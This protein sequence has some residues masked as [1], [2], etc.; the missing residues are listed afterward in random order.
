[1]HGLRTSMVMKRID[2]FLLLVLLM[3]SMAAQAQQSP[4]AKARV[5]QIRKAYTE[6]KNNVAAADKAAK[7][8]KPTNM[9]VV[10][11]IYTLGLGAGSVT[12]TYYFTE[13]EDTLLGRS[14]YKP[15]FIVN[16]YNTPGNKYY[17]EFLYD[18]DDDLIFYYEKNGGQ[19]TRLYFGKEGEND[20][21]GLVYEINTSSRTM[22]PPFA[23]RVGGELMHAFHLLMNREF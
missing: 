23:H 13:E 16:N 7:A 11:S 4:E 15:Y 5:A 14:F 2:I 8:G 10:N 12:T 20:D 22:E 6:A 3:G 9:T 19:E 1:M 18:K 17:Q 21:E